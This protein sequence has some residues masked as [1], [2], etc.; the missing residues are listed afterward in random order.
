[1]PRGALGVV[2]DAVMVGV[3][4]VEPLA[5][6]AVALG[7]G[8]RRE[9]IV[10]GLLPIEPGPSLGAQ[11]LFGKLG[12]DLDLA[13]FDKMQPPVAVLVEGDGVGGGGWRFAPARPE[14][15]RQQATANR[16]A[17]AA[18]VYLAIAFIV[19]LLRTGC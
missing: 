3:D 18:S 14:R 1:M 4:L 19:T 17:V 13:F 10:I 8:H 11:T 7:R 2:D 15:A 12:G 9:E 6:A 16:P 5:E